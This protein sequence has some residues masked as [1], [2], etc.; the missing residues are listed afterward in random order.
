MAVLVNLPAPEGKQVLFVRDRAR[1]GIALADACFVL[2]QM[3]SAVTSCDF[4]HLYYSCSDYGLLQGWSI[5]WTNLVAEQKRAIRQELG[6]QK[7][8]PKTLIA[9]EGLVYLFQRCLYVHARKLDQQTQEW[10][11]NVLS[12]MYRHS[13]TSKETFSYAKA[14]GYAVCHIKGDLPWSLRTPVFDGFESNRFSTLDTDLRSYFKATGAGEA[15]VNELRYFVEMD[16]LDKW[17]ATKVIQNSGIP[18]PEIESFV[19]AWRAQPKT[20]AKV[21]STSIGAKNNAALEQM[22]RQEYLNELHTKVRASIDAIKGNAPCYCAGK[23][24][25]APAVASWDLVPSYSQR[26]KAAHRQ[27]S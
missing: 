2:S 17:L 20:K 3:L 21:T 22:E 10:V 7:K 8:Q 14:Q 19:T 24:F 12:P 13:T 6:Y 25:A 4:Y 5:F 15:K 18:A 16:V 1:A 9:P 26:F 27:A 23:F 11:D